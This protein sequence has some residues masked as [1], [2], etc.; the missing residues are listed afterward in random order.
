MT[1][2]S[3]VGPVFEA[4]GVAVAVGPFGPEGVREAGQQRPGRARGQETGGDRFEAGAIAVLLQRVAGDPAAGIG[5]AP[6]DSV[7]GAVEVSV[8]LATVATGA[9][10]FGG[11]VS[12]T[13]RET[14]VRQSPSLVGI[15]S[16]CQTAALPLGSAATPT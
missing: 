7:T 4:A 11:T 1:P 6:A 10:V 2:G 3:R 15:W 8:P 12:R 5:A 9:V 14:I 13:S 16:D